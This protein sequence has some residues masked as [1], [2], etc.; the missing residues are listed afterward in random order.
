MADEVSAEDLAVPDEAAAAESSETRPDLPFGWREAA[1]ILLLALV[2]GVG[3][4][5]LTHMSVRPINPSQ[6]APTGHFS[7]RC[8]LCHNVSAS[9][10]LVQE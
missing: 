10:K 8:G 1:T 6:K 9:V 5:G 2:L 3:V 4:Y 7:L